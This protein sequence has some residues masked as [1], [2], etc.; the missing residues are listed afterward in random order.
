MAELLDVASL[1]VLPGA[2]HM[3]WLKDEERVL[4]S[5]LD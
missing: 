3:G 2:G 4:L 1:E 5:L